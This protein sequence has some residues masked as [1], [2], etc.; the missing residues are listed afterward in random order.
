MIEI[1]KTVNPVE[2][3]LALPFIASIDTYYP[4]IREW[5][6]NTVVPGICTGNDILLVAKA[7]G[8]IAG[9]VLAKTGEEQKLRCIRVADTY[10]GLG[11]GIKLIDTAL[12]L[13]GDKPLVSVSQELLH[14]YSRMFVNRY[15]FLLSDVVKGKYRQGKLEYFFNQ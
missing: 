10:R 4:N 6:V 1:H 12:E 9:I 13:I 3:M 15:G 7:R 2:A 11:L 14:D 5:Y 8:S